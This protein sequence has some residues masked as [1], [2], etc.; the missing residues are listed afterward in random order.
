MTN[1]TS[2]ATASALP[3]PGPLRLGASADSSDC[4]ARVVPS[5]CALRRRSGAPVLRPARGKDLMR[6]ADLW[7]GALFRVQRAQPE[8][9]PIDPLASSLP[10]YSIKHSASQRAS[11]SAECVLLLINA[12]IRALAHRIDICPTSP[13]RDRCRARSKCC[14]PPSWACFAQPH[15]RA[16]GQ[17]LREADLCVSVS[18]AGTSHQGVISL[19]R[20]GFVVE[21][22]VSS[23]SG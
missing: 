1:A 9:R 8:M 5:S 16:G 18:P 10:Q 17:P 23:A 22:S 14:S 2:T 20:I 15:R 19:P 7:I 13:S 21:E 6:A 3:P 12:D 4:E 11:P